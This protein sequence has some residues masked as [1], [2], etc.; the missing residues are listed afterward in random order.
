MKIRTREHARMA[1]RRNMLLRSASLLN[2]IGAIRALTVHMATEEAMQEHP[3][4]RHLNG[5]AR[6]EESLRHAQTAVTTHVLNVV[7]HNMK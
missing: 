6:I 2:H 7:F 4:Q 1:R 5:L 3:N